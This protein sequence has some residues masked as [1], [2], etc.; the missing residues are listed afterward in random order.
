M[1]I[2]Y[3]QSY[4]AHTVASAR[5]EVKCEHCSCVFIYQLIREGSGSGM[6]VLFLDNQGAEER[7]SAEA[8][9]SLA[10]QLARD[11]DP[12][13]CP[14]CL[15]FQSDMI[16]ILKAG[17]RLWLF[18]LG[19][20]FTIPSAIA[21]VG[22]VAW[23]AES[24]REW[25]P[26]IVASSVAALVVGL[27]MILVRRN[28]VAHLDPNTLSEDARRR[29]ATTQGYVPGEEEESRRV[30]QKDVDERLRGETKYDVLVYGAVGLL[31]IVLGTCI[32]AL[33]WPNIFDGHASPNWPTTEGTI[34]EFRIV[35][36]VVERRGNKTVYFKPQV[37]FDYVVAD[38]SYR[39]Q[40][41]SW[42]E[43]SSTDRNDFTQMERTLMPG[44]TVQVYY[45]A[46]DPMN[47]VLLPGVD[48][49][50]Y[51][52]GVGGIVVFLLGMGTS[53]YCF[54]KWREERSM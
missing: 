15:L 19:L 11:I 21:L 9:A 53:I 44:Q 36:S 22:T 52:F 16:P 54:V 7:A 26:A 13:L 35:P 20:L 51:V 50:D 8:N 34:R 33:V 27:T 43:I 47:S 23:C 1:S 32:S 29:L 46:S 48:S 12:V 10:K 24:G 18:Y 42:A 30:A 40:R 39:G 4:T 28:Q 3:G 49:N 5:R 38:V 6:S 31:C 14:K 25:P 41:L 45:K 37:G 2:P 17:Y